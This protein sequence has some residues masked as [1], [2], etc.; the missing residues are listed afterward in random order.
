MVWDKDKGQLVYRWFRPLN[1]RLGD[2]H[3][4]LRAG[5]RD[6]SGFSLGDFGYLRLPGVGEY[7]A[8]VVLRTPRGTIYSPT[9]KFHVVDVP[10]AD[11]LDSQMIPNEG[12]RAKRDWN[13]QEKLTIQQLR[14][15]G[16]VYLVLRKFYGEKLGG[17][18][19]YSVRLRRLPGK[20]N[21]SVEGEYGDRPTP[22]TI[23]YKD[24]TAPTGTTTLVISPF[25]GIWDDGSRRIA[26]TPR[27]INP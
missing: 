25:G 24:E 11:V 5:E 22:I 4:Y 1:W 18:V 26:P 27:P 10:P 19:S 12:A 2:L 16:R 21:L 13:D 6:S 20:V 23:R 17:A 14:L 7:E 15:G 3:A 8:R 9:W